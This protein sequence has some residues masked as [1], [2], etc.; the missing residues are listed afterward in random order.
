MNDNGSFAFPSSL[1]LE[2]DGIQL[3]EW[4]D[5][6]V[7]DLVALYDDPVMARWTPVAS[8]FDTGAALTYLADA[9]VGQ[10]QGRK[11]QLAITTD[12]VRPRGEVLLFR[13]ERDGRDLE[14]AYGVGAAHR[15]QGLAGR[16]VRLA[17][18]YA[19]R[20]LRPRRVLLCIDADNA[21]SEAV[22]R[23]C[24]FELA[25]DAP[26]RRVSRGREV[27]LRTWHLGAH[28]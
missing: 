24:D 11:L 6:D 28:G 18:G 20:E 8:P 17:A 25:D 3:R 27:F 22:A 1:R 5:G 14:L 10:S 7:P 4:A 2:G 19:A 12:G 13:S 16:A 23:A 26:V 9:W 15:G 21:A